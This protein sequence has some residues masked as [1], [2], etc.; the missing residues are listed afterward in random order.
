MP[1]AKWYLLWAKGGGRWDWVAA[2]VADAADGDVTGYM[3]DGAERCKAA[4]LISPNMSIHTEVSEPLFG[5]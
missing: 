3:R 2:E 4:Q 1:S 5:V